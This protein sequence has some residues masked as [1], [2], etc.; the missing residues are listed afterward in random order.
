M[1]EPDH[2]QHDRLSPHTVHDLLVLLTVIR[3]QEH[4]VRRWVRL[5]DDSDG[6]E[7][8]LERL[9]ATDALIQQLAAELIA[10]EVDDGEAPDAR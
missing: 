2:R 9:A 7:K 1:P 10:R 8:V 4:L 3:G 6:F 5:R